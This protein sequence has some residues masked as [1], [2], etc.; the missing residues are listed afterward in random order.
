MV[1][2]IRIEVSHGERCRRFSVLSPPPLL[3]SKCVNAIG[4]VVRY[5]RVKVF[6]CSFPYRMLRC[7]PPQSRVI[8]PLGGTGIR[9]RRRRQPRLSG[10][11]GSQPGRSGDR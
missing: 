2:W 10:L 7:P 6:A 11:S 1:Y 8:V 5:T 4:D 3:G 9:G